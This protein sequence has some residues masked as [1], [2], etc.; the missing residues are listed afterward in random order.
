MITF[1]NT[2]ILHDYN[3]Q[4]RCEGFHS[5]RLDYY[6]TLD[7]QHKVILHNKNYY[8]TLFHLNNVQ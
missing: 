7:L 6:W 2:N 3:K 4:V 5:L 8:C 1:A